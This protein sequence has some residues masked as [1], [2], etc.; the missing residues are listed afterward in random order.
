MVNP[1]AG[2]SACL[3]PSPRPPPTNA[4]F[5]YSSVDLLDPSGPLETFLGLLEFP[6]F[7]DPPAPRGCRT[8]LAAKRISARL[9]QFPHELFKR[10]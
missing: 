2:R 5:T 3:R 7:L 8:A 9:Y 10:L 6:E 4:P 1:Q